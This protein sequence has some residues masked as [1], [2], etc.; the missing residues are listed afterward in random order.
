[1]S[2]QVYPKERNL[3]G[4]YYRVK[5]DGIWCNRC[6]TD[7]TEA[8]QNEFMSRLD[9][10]GL[11]RVCSFLANKCCLNKLIYLWYSYKYRPSIYWQQLTLQPLFALKKK[12]ANSSIVYIF[13]A[14]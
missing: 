13:S 8:E 12:D 7:L 9:E 1:M 2:E 10:E 14:S 4:V 3:D 5:R 6:Y 11:K